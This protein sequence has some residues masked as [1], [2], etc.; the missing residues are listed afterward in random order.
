VRRA[1]AHSTRFR[2]RSSQNGSG[3]GAA[4]DFA[5]RR[6]GGC[7]DVGQG[8]A[9]FGADMRYNCLAGAELPPRH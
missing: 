3:G 2:R 6:F 1:A 5:E 4:H 9:G 7:D 8:P